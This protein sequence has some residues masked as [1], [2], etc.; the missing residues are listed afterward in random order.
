M[1]IKIMNTVL[2]LN[3]KKILVLEFSIVPELILN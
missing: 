1:K 2:S 3:Q